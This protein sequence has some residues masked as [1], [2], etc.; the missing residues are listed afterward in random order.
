[1]ATSQLKVKHTETNGLASL[2]S[3]KVKKNTTKEKKIE[4]PDIQKIKADWNK[5]LKYL[6]DKGVQGKPELD[7][8]GLGNKYFDEYV[9]AN[10]GT[11]LSTAVIP[12]I[13]QAYSELRNTNI[14]TIK[15]GKGEFNGKSGPDV[16]FSGFM[17]HIEKNEKSE[18][19]N[20]VGQHL[21]R[22]PFPGILNYDGKQAVPLYTLGQSKDY[23]KTVDS[24]S[25]N[26]LKIIKK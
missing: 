24:V 20:Y 25:N 9:K 10:P 3:L 2:N 17:S 14:E 19:P 7:K 11:S 13:R 16:D 26:K 23:Y 15:K 1:M 6:S 21:T 18:N 22:T 8:G 4:D 5:Y 12:K